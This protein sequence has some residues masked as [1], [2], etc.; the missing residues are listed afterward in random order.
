MKHDVDR[1]GKKNKLKLHALE[2]ATGCTSWICNNWTAGVTAGGG[3]GVLEHPEHP[4]VFTPIMHALV[5]IMQCRS[6]HCFT[7]SSKQSIHFPPPQI[8]AA[9]NYAIMPMIAW[10]GFCAPVHLFI[11]G[12][13]CHAIWIIFFFGC[14]S[15]R[16]KCQR[17]R[18]EVTGGQSASH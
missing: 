6:I 3:G 13:A 17:K 14:V 5:Y 16:S 9:C 4:P 2:H 1:T 8:L 11:I 18:P 12:C 7:Q 10:Q 15:I